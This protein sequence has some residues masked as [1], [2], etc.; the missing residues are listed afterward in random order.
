M[1]LDG[2]QRITL[3]EYLAALDENKRVAA[4]VGHRCHAVNQSPTG[5]GCQQS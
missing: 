2:N 1:D 4:A 5:H 3:A